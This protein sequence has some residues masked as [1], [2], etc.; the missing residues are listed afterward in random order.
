MK[1]NGAVTRD[2]N[3]NFMLITLLKIVVSHTKLLVWSVVMLNGMFS[4]VWLKCPNIR[5][6]TYMNGGGNKSVIT[7]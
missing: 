5:Y 2:R 7:S 1:H 3:E 4:L 6:L